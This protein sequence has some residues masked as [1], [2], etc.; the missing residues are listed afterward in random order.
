[1]PCTAPSRIARSPEMSDRYSD[2]SVVWNVY[3]APSATDHA[4]A[5]SVA[6]PVTSWCTAKLALI[7]APLTSAPWRYRA[8]T[9]APMPFGH[10]AMMSMSA[11][12]SSPF[13]FR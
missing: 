10:T 4:R 6:R 13:W 7:P 5:R 11:G 12:K 1:M 9:E 8:R 2:S 3:G